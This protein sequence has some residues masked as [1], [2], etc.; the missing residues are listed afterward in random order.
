MLVLVLLGIELLV[1]VQQQF[2]P[3]EEPYHTEGLLACGQLSKLGGSA[4]EP[5]SDRVHDL[6]IVVN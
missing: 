6:I 2:D 3:N 4:L 5:V 1:D